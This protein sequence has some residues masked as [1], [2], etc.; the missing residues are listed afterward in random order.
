ME[1]NMID[2]TPVLQALIALLASWITIRV[3]PWLKA[4]TSKQQQDYL[5]S[6]TRVLVY[7]AEQL[8]RAGNGAVKLEYVEDELERRGLKVDAAAIEAAVHEMNLMESWE[9]AFESD[10]TEDEDGGEA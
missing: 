1:M 7:A 3:I 6:T 5:L 4:K 9:E 8:F 2:L 10:E